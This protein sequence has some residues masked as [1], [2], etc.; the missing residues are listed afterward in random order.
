MRWFWTSPPL[1]YHRRFVTGAE[2]AVVSGCREYGDVSG[3]ACALTGGEEYPDP[4]LSKSD[5]RSCAGGAAGRDGGL[6]W[7][8]DA[9]G[10]RT[11]TGSCSMV[12]W[13]YEPARV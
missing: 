3:R 12:T 8:D 6:C 11:R 10:Q 5:A 4:C 13:R 2:Y 1:Y 9:P 7:W